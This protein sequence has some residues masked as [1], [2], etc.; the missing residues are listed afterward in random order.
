LKNAPQPSSAEI[1][2]RER[3]AEEGWTAVVPFFYALV[4]LQYLTEMDRFPEHRKELSEVIHNAVPLR[5]Y[6]PIPL[7]V[8]ISMECDEALKQL[9]YYECFEAVKEKYHDAIR[10]EGLLE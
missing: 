8:D 3:K 2:D 4:F 6:D 5:M 1:A 10:R 9:G 7:T